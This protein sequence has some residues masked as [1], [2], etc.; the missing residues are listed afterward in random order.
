M[1]DWAETF[2]LATRGDDDEP[3]RVGAIDGRTIEG[4]RLSAARRAFVAEFG[5]DVDPVRLREAT[6]L[7]TGL[8]GLEYAIARG[9]VDAIMTA[10]KISN[11]LMRL[12]REM[13]G[14]KHKEVSPC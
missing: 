6:L 1:H 3:R 14:A 12:R 8:Q 4:R 10:S 7:Y 13:A 2:R 9:N 11:T 5:A